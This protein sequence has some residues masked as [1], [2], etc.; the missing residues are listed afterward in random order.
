MAF[1]ISLIAIAVSMTFSISTVANSDL[2]ELLQNCL[3]LLIAFAGM[4]FA[5]YLYDDTFENENIE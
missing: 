1:W 2:S 3:T 4:A 5:I